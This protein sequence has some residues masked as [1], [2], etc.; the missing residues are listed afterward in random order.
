[1]K[2]TTKGG[3]KQRIEKNI[4]SVSEDTLEFLSLDDE[5][6]EAYGRRM[7]SASSKASQKKA[8]PH[9]KKETPVHVKNEKDRKKR[10]TY[11]D[12]EQ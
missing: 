2:K 11:R 9:K 8:A 10:K 5:T 6:I 3:R 4:S 7:Q 1:M 12:Y